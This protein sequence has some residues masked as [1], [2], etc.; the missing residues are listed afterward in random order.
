LAGGFAASA[1]GLAAGDT[2]VSVTRNIF[3]IG[4]MEVA[5]FN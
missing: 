5:L 1:A 2:S 4:F 3:M